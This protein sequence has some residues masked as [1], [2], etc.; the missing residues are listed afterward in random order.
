MILP[1]PLPQH[2]HT[3][4]VRDVSDKKKCAGAEGE[5]MVIC[6]CCY[7]PASSSS[8][9]CC[10]RLTLEKWSLDDSVFF[11]P[12]LVFFLFLFFFQC[13]D[14]CQ[15]EVVSAFHCGFLIT[16]LVTGDQH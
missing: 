12:V 7:C 4:F 16:K 5:E 2:Q 11:M 15:H 10:H 6:C 14:S 8:G 13:M 9:S 3:Y 1:F